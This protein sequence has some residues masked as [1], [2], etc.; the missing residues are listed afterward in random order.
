M[1]W[2]ASTKTHIANLRG[3][4]SSVESV[5]FSADGST[6]ASA[7]WDGTVQLWDGRTGGHIATLDGH[8]YGARSAVFSVDGSRLISTYEDHAGLHLGDSDSATQSCPSMRHTVLLWDV[9]NV[10]RPYLLCQKTAV[11]VYNGARNCLFFLD[12]RTEPALCGLTV[13]N[14]QDKSSL[15]HKSSVGS[16][17]TFLLV[18]FLCILRG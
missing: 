15:T 1:L 16:L 3:H 9:S 14:L 13:L 4:T 17:P 10:A 12:T 5:N 8:S 7:S 11:V 6:L 18:A 2:D